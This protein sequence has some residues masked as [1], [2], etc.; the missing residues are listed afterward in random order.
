MIDFTPFDSLISIMNYFDSNDMCVAFLE[1]QRWN[2][3]PVCPYCGRRHANHRSNGRWQ[4]A[5]CG[6]SFSVLQGTIFENTKVP[7]RK[8]FI[9]M[10][11]IASNKK[12]VSSSQIARDINVTQKTAWFML[13]KIRTL[14]K[15]DMNGQLSGIVECDEMY[16]GGKETNKHE[17]RKQENTQG[18]SLKVKTPVFGMCECKYEEV[19]GKR[20]ANTFVRA[21]VVR[22]TKQS[23]IIPI[24]TRNITKGT[25]VVTDELNIYNAIPNVYDHRT[26]CHK[27]KEFSK[28]NGICT[29]HIEGFW[30][31]MRRMVV[32]VY[33]KIGRVYLQHYVDEAVFRHNTRNCTNGERFQMLF[34]RSIGVVDYGMIKVA[35]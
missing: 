35:A 30:G 12:G 21:M 2:G 11:E 17:C 31:T 10:Y 34:S 4:C 22:D 3:V 23:T 16:H 13:Q 8:W 28:G 27:S 24:I 32:G 7:L 9:A 18:R 5:K 20:F 6:K 1:E 26:V 19:D 29:N 25:M 14:M 15:Q 33:H